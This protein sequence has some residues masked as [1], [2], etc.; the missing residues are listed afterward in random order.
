MS[1]FNIDCPRSIETYCES[2]ADICP[3]MALTE[4]EK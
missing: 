3:R 2:D 1:G 4:A